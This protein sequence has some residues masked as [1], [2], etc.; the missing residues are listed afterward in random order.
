MVPGV[1]VARLTSNTWSVTA[2]GFGGRFANKL[3]VLVDGRSIY[4]P[5]FA[6]VYWEA[7]GVMLEDVDRIE[8]IRGP[9]G[10]LWGANA[11]NGVINIVTKAAVDTQGLLLSTGAGSYER[12]FG[13]ARWGGAAGDDVHYRVYTRYFLRDEGGSQATGGD[14]DDAWQS[15][16][17]GGRVDWDISPD[18]RLSLYA[19]LRHLDI[20]EVIMRSFLTPPFSQEV[21]DSPD[22]FGR[23]VLAAWDHAFADESSIQLQAYYDG[24]TW[25]DPT[26]AEDRN[27]FDI[28]FQHQLEVGDRHNIIWGA[29]FRHTQDDIDGSPSISLTPNSRGDQTYSAFVQDD[30]ALTDK[31]HFILG[32]KIEH[33]D[34]TGIEVQPNARLRWTPNDRHTLWAAVSRAVRTPSRAESD[35]R[36]RSTTGPGPAEIV[37]TRY[38]DRDY[39]SEDLLATELGYRVRATDE[40]AIDIALFFNH[41]TDFRTLEPGPTFVD[42]GVTVLPIEALNEGKA[43]TYGFEIAADWQPLRLWQLRAGYSYLHINLEVPST[44]PVT[45]SFSGDTPQNQF[46]LQNRLNLPHSVEFDTALRYVDSLDGIGIGSYIELDAR[47]AWRPID[48]LELALV[49]RNLLDNEHQE[50]APTFVNHVP[51]AV[52][53]EVYGKITWRFQPGGK[54]EQ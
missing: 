21:H 41:Y 20:D 7:H 34:Y 48:D 3:L 40:L 12:A 11:V 29:G 13:S 15:I 43:N 25:E 19:D 52:E 8:V 22:Y 24:Y 31:L 10:T 18:D 5:L 36:L 23:Y 44:D 35:V 38:D 53:R 37:F 45:E 47:L 17:G 32:A 14:A 54:N 33:N 6:G 2:R 9:G 39:E 27:T 16:Q 30:I 42:N 49:G 1:N 4:T 51:T 50:F 46:F 26:F 28:E